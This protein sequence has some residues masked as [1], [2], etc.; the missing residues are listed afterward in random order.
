MLLPSHLYALGG[1]GGFGYY[2]T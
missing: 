1:P 2:T